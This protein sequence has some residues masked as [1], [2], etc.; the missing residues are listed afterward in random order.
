MVNVLSVA[1]DLH[2]IDRPEFCAR[3]KHQF[4]KKQWKGFTVQVSKS[5]D[6]KR[7]E[8]LC[9]ILRLVMLL[10]YPFSYSFVSSS[11]ARFPPQR[12]SQLPRVPV[13]S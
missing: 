13:P 11:S 6:G 2:M 9:I 4:H 7:L 3:L 1:F 12:V 5:L 10:P 8:T